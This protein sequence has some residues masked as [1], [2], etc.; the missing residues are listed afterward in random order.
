MKTATLL[1]ACLMSST[2]IAKTTVVF[3]L[4]IEIDN[5][6]VT[7]AEINKKFNL[8][9]T[10]KLVE[11]LTVTNEKN[12]T[13][14]ARDL[15]WAQ[16]SKV[17]E[18]SEKLNENFFLA[19]SGPDSCY[20][21]APAEAVQILNGLTDGPF[22]DQQVISGYR[23]KK[24]INFMDSQNEEE[25]NDYLNRESMAWKNW[26]GNDESILIVYS[27]SDGGDDINEALVTKCK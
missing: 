9:G 27:T 17:E 1:I 2:L 12:S 4:Q 10:D 15:F 14:K 21:G 6:I 5:K 18:L 16:H 11:T 7:S 23:Y 19:L 26:K 13:Q 24:V 22:S 20:I 8:K 3:P 25:S